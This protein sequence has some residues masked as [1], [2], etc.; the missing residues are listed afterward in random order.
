VRELEIFGRTFECECGR[1]HHVEPGQVIYAEDAAGPLADAAGGVCQGRR[2]AV[3]MDVRTREAAGAAVAAAFGAAGWDVTEVLVEDPA[4]DTGPVCDDRTRAALDGRLGAPDLVC[5]VGGGVLSDLGKWIALDRELP[6]VTFGTA[7]SMNGYASANIA[8]TIDNVK[9]LVYGRPPAVVASAPSVL[10]NAPAE[11]TAS[12]LGDVLAKSVSSTDWRMNHRLFGDYYCPHSVA[13]IEDIE[14]M[15]LDRPEALPAGEPAAF[16]AIFAA[17]LLTGAA[18]TMADTSS[19]A[20]GGEH[21]IGHSLDMMSLADGRPHDL[22]GR[23][24]GIGTILAS[25][26]YR[27]VLEMDSPD[28]AD[29]P[30]GIDEAFWGPIAR[31]VRPE[32]EAKQPRLRA[33]GQML[34]EGS[35]WDDLRADLATMTRPPG[36]TRD[37]LRAAGAACRLED[38]GCP[39]DRLLGAFRHAHEIRSR[40]TILDLANLAGLMPAAAGEIV[41]EWT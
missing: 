9:R 39:R 38:I 16:E 8:P 33:A 25:E 2:V 27:R 30:A 14:P 3:L 23:Q 19:P 37:C 5:P 6:Y 17:L 40:F 18:M 26:L 13:L 15:Y 7:A 22:H 32:Y 36:R 28:W 34:S 21:L 31:E 12:G 24:V 10:I 41:E 35:A 4:P 29:A 1:T 11:L 20:S